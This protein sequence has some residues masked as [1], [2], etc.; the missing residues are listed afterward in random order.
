[1]KYVV[2]TD[3]MYAQHCTICMQSNMVLSR[4]KLLYCQSDRALE[5][6]AQ[7]GCGVSFSGDIQDLSGCL[8]V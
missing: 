8:P 3:C 7:R 6:A 4:E 2:V 5:Q 1:M